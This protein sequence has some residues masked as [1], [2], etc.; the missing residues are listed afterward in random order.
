MTVAQ[1]P[2]S[3][4]RC[5]E[6]ETQRLA[7]AELEIPGVASTGLAVSPDEALVALSGEHG[8]QIWSLAPI[9]ARD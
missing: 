5:Y 8:L 1:P 9:L 3:I 6:P 7:R 2:R 4:L